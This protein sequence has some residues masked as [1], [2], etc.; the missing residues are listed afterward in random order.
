MPVERAILL[1]D[2]DGFT[3]AEA[4]VRFHAPGFN[5][6]VYVRWPGFRE[7]ADLLSVA[8]FDPDL[9]AVID[10]ARVAARAYFS[11]RTREHERETIER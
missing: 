7:R 1:C 8:E 11:E 9:N 5:F 2:E 4:Q 3:L 10:S 6:T